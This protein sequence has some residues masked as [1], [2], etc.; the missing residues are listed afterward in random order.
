H[1]TKTKFNN[2][3]I[4]NPNLIAGPKKKQYSRRISYVGKTKVMN[5]GLEATVIEDFGCN[6]ITVQFED[7][8]I[9]KHRRREHFDSGKI[10]HV[11]DENE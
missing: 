6:D 2:G 8:L 4:K 3:T 10:R 7:G 9:R 1:T 11:A 5:C